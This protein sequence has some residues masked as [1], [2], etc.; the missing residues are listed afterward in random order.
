MFEFESL[1]REESRLQS[2]QSRKF[3]ANLQLSAVTCGTCIFAKLSK[4]F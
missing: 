2:F 4:C 3:T 1:H